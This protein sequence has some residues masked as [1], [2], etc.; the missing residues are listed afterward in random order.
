MNISSIIDSVGQAPIDSLENAPDLPRTT[1]SD[2]QSE[3]DSQPRTLDMDE[4]RLLAN[5]SFFDGI[6][7]TNI[8][9]TKT[10]Q[11]LIRP[12]W[13]IR[14][15]KLSK[16]YELQG[17]AVEDAAG[18]LGKSTRAYKFFS[19]RQALSCD[20]CPGRAFA[21]TVYQRHQSSHPSQHSTCVYCNVSFASWSGFKCHTDCGWKKNVV[22]VNDHG[23]I[24]FYCF[25]QLVRFPINILRRIVNK[26]QLQG[27]F[28]QVSL[29]GLSNRDIIGFFIQQLRRSI[30]ER[31]NSIEKLDELGETACHSI[32]PD[33]RIIMENIFKT[34][35]QLLVS[36]GNNQS[37]Y[38][39][40]PLT[41]MMWDL[42]A[43]RGYK[44]IPVTQENLARGHKRCRPPEE[45]QP[46][47]LKWSCAKPNANPSLLPGRDVETSLSQYPV[48][49][50]NGAISTSG[51]RTLQQSTPLQHQH[52]PHFSMAVSSVDSGSNSLAQASQAALTLLDSALPSDNTFGSKGNAER[53]HAAGP[54][55]TTDSLIVERTQR[56]NVC[57]PRLMSEDMDTANYKQTTAVQLLQIH[58]A[59]SE[60]GDRLAAIE[61]HPAQL[62]TLPDPDQGRQSIPISTPQQVAALSIG[63]MA[64]YE[65]CQLPLHI[66]VESQSLASHS[67]NAVLVNA[68]ASPPSRSCQ[69]KS[70]H[71]AQ[72]AQAQQDL[73]DKN[74]ELGYAQGV[75][76]ERE[77]QYKKTMEVLEERW[78]ALREA[79]RAVHEAAGALGKN[80][81][82]LVHAQEAQE[83]RQDA[84]DK[85]NAR[86]KRLWERY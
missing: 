37:M 66:S 8:V 42:E 17:H 82:E 19:D 48:N 38:T 80:Q 54:S 7:Y 13:S 50:L 25:Q 15:A 16:L 84:V 65:Q 76:K 29:E 24:F 61:S 81:K 49:S 26:Y 47:R 32:H 72:I 68:D 67:D 9:H 58:S 56:D 31:S 33:S 52:I 11:G 83:M 85:A 64:K 30:K 4:E 5:P 43:L 45:R 59:K 2:I 69:K 12:E 23:T 57:T 20:F 41:L 10:R 35:R 39:Q 75:Q 86:L 74:R 78:S 53:A 62:P 70:H 34:V 36:E 71:S 14:D 28:V 63:K 22:N 21:V 55:S 44:D 46:K 79:E 18:S 60:N 73:C 6:D 3:N 1:A 77:K 51:E 40:L 27:D